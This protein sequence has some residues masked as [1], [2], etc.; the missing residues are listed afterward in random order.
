MSYRKAHLVTTLTLFMQAMEIEPLYST[1]YEDAWPIHTYAARYLG[2][3]AFP[4]RDSAAV[5]FQQTANS[6]VLGGE[7]VPDIHLALPAVSHPHIFKFWISFNTHLLLSLV[8]F[9]TA[10][11]AMYR[12]RKRKQAAVL[13]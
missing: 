7:N 6:E 9:G 8:P 11:F 12:R 3:N 1:K 13:V 5:A 10:R 2:Q 4:G